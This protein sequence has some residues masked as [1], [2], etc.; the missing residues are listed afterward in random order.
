MPRIMP[1]P[2]YFSI[3]SVVV[4]AAALRNEALNWTLRYQLTKAE[5]VAE[6]ASVG[7]FVQQYQV[8]V[9][10]KKLQAYGLTLAQLTAAIRASNRDV[11]GRVVE[12]SETE[13]VVRGRGYLRNT[14][15][16]E[17]IALKMQGGRRCCCATSRASSSAPKSAAALPSSTAKA[18]WSAASRCSATARTRCM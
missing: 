15:D 4:G 1:E 13:Y 16:L 3:P 5:G 2:R 14:G 17:Q 9:D 8:V 7:G 12:M 11:G 18:K 6:V 10:P